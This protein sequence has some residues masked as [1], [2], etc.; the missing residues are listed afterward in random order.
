MTPV[1]LSVDAIVRMVADGAADIA[2]DHPARILVDGPSWSGLDLGA[3]VTAQL[4]NAG[5]QTVH[6][7]AEDY[8][9]PASLRFE[10][11]RDDAQAFADDW[12]DYAALRREVLNPAGPGGSR[13]VLPTLWDVTTDRATR[14]SYVDLNE[15]A[16]VVVSGQLL[17]GRGL[18]AEL[19]VHVHLSA[20]ARRRR[21]PAVDADRELPAYAWYDEHVQP[22]DTADVVVRADDPRR[23]ALLDR[24]RP[25]NR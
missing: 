25:G 3:R 10:R 7:R 4:T 2:R 24:R 13:R 6:V 12:V 15:G 18:P 9:R 11:G 17:L 5:M 23:P 16:V 14:A 8:L 1:P 19:T 20:A 22:E 21:V